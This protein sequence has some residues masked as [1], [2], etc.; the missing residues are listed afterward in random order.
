MV[1]ICANCIDWRI[2][3]NYVIRAKQGGQN[4][5]T[6]TNITLSNF[7]NTL[8]KVCPTSTAF[9]ADKNKVVIFLPLT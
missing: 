1:K 3:V 5:S 4:F 2:L 8:L 7:I 9:V 6:K